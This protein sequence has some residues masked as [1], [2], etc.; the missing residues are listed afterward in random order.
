MI[1]Q[2][3]TTLASS[4]DVRLLRRFSNVGS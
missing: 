1:Q 2:T 3:E 4:S